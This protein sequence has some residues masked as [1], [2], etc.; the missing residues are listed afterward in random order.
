M[1]T[2]LVVDHSPALRTVARRILEEIGYKVTGAGDGMAALRACRE[3]MPDLMTGLEFV[4]ALR[5]LPEGDHPQILFSTTE[6][7]TKQ[8]ASAKA[9]GAD[10]FVVKPFDRTQVRS[11][12]SAI[13]LA[14]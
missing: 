8:I 11:K 10:T 13:G 12:L 7:N 1:T 3:T 4:K 14:A 2:C 9:A 5:G 6:M